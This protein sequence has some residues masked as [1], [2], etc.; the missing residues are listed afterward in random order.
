[1]QKVH[2]QTIEEQ[3]TVTLVAWNVFEVKL[4]HGIAP[5][6]H[7]C[8]FRKETARGKV[9]SAISAL[10][11]DKR[12]C[13]TRSGNVYELQGSPGSSTD[14]LA[15]RGQWL[16]MNHVQNDIGVTTEFLT[17]LEQGGQP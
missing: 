1:M 14:A 16:Q 2:I 7:L 15:T 13:I 12:R 11:P 5:T 6:W 3:A 10:D 8:G 9:S 17:Y 4:P